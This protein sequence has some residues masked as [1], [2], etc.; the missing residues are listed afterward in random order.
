MPSRGQSGIAVYM[1]WNTSTNVY[2]PGDTA[3]HTIVFV[4]DGVFTTPANTATEVS[5]A[6]VIGA[7]Q[8]A[9]SS[10]EGSCNTLWVGGRSSSANVAIIPITIAFANTPISGLATANVVQING[11]ATVTSSAQIGVNVFNWQGALPA[12]LV[13]ALVQTQVSGAVSSVT[14]SVG[15]VTGSVASVTS[16]VNVTQILGTVVQTSSVQLGVNVLTVGSLTHAPLIG[17][18]VQAT[19]S[20]TL[21]GGVNVTQ[22][23]GGSPAPLV[24]A[25]VQTSVSGTVSSVGSVTGTVASVTS[26]VN[27]TQ[28]LGSTPAPLSAALVQA[29]VSGVPSVNVTQWNGGA[30]N[31]LVAGRVDASAGALA[32]GVI[33]TGSFASAAITATTTD[34]TF[35]QAVATTL[36]D[37]ANAIETGITPRQALRYIAA[38]EAGVTTGA[39]TNTFTISAISATGSTRITATTD[40]S[41]N[42]QAVTLS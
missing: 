26:G 42:R 14:G 3:N 6:G 7:Y 32:S 8:I 1:A 22:W 9:W 23:Q 28:W 21:S 36:L 24:N 31:N 37:S 16:G 39:L 35:N 41:G 4:K 34:S 18:L 12:P 10:S 5:G 17:G 13:N 20:G 29:Q 15:S 11:A 33:V 30:P 2:A 25:L 27:V 40:S 38:A 19:V